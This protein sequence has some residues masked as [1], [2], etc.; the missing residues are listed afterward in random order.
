[1]EPLAERALAKSKV[2][3]AVP[4]STRNSPLMAHPRLKAP[5]KY[6]EIDQEA[7][8]TFWREKEQSTEERSQAA[9][10][11]MMGNDQ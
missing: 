11:S 7:E 2:V 9:S 4:D 5:V 6:K 1:M 10:A 3:K 8:T